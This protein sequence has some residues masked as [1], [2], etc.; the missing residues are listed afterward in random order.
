VYL[1]EGTF[2]P[3]KTLELVTADSGLTIQNYN[4]ERVVISGGIPLEITWEPYNVS[5][6]DSW[7]VAQ[8]ENDVYGFTPTP[9]KY[10]LNSTQ[11]SWGAC[12]TACQANYTEGGGCNAW[13]WHDGNQGTYSYDCVFRFDGVW[14]LRAQSGHVSGRYMQAPNVWRAKVGNPP[15]D[16]IPGLR[17]NGG[18]GI[19]ARYPNAN[20]ETDG[21]GSELKANSW[22]PSILPTHPDREVNPPTPLRNTSGSFQKYQL[23]VGGPCEIF[24]PSAGYWCGNATSGENTYKMGGPPLRFPSLLHA[25][26][27]RARF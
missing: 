17:V 7:Q 20:P 25:T 22:G 24:T 21:F 15:T 14:S 11:Q 4:G 19:R 3:G 10:L 9:G 5:K 16:G 1:R 2:Y 23:G 27:T 12:Q 26:P 13:T 8:D 6:H 18:R